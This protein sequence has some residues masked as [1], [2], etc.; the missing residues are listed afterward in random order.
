MGSGSNSSYFS[1]TDANFESRPEH[2]LPCTR[3]SLSFLDKYRNSPFNSTATVTSPHLASSI[4]YPA[5]IRGRVVQV[6]E[7]VIK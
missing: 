7:R 3:F 6:V 5:I 2:R 4:H 1:L